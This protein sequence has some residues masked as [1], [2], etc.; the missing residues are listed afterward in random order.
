MLLGWISKIRKKKKKKTRKPQKLDI[1]WSTSEFFPVKHIDFLSPPPNRRDENISK[2]QLLFL[3]HTFSLTC[4][5]IVIVEVN[6]QPFGILG[7]EIVLGFTL[8]L[9]GEWEWLCS[10]LRSHYLLFY[11]GISTNVNEWKKWLLHL[12]NLAQTTKNFPNIVSNIT[13]HNQLLAK[14]KII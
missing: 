7:P 6:C 12:G 5:S 11:C 13:Q 8:S 10:R 14:H 3:P 2:Y 4:H 9:T 1:R